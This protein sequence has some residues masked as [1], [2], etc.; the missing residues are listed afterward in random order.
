M[1]QTVSLAPVRGR[2]RIE[3]IDILRGVAIL[4]IFFVNLPAMMGPL[5]AL[6]GDIRSLG[7]SP[8]D[9]TTWLLMQTFWEGTQRGMLEFLFGAGLMV[10]AAKAMDGDGP[11]AVADLYIRRNLW[12][13]AFGLIN[14]FALLWIADILHVY[15]LSALALF[16]FRKLKVKWLI[17]IGLSLAT[18]QLAIGAAEYVSRTDLHQTYQ[19]ASAKRDKGQTLTSEEAA[20]VKEWN[21]RVAKVAAG[22]PEI[23]KLTKEEKAAR[24]GSMGDYAGFMISTY[25]WSLGKGVLL[26]N[27]LEAFSLML[28]G[29]AAWKLGFIQG[30]RSTRE[31]W[32]VLALAY[33]FGL[34]ARYVGALEIMA[35]APIPKTIWMTME[36]ARIAVTIGHIAAINLLVRVTA[37]RSLLAPF[38]AAGQ[39][40]FSLYLMQQIIGVWI[41]YS[42]VGLH[43]PSA[44]GWAYAA[45]LA[46]LVVVFQLVLANI[47]VRFFVSGPLEW[48]W[49]SLA[50]CRKQ[51]FRRRAAASAD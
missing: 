34:T 7:W 27:V 21:E 20:A 41:L 32:L 18:L 51:P 30:K 43:L 42:P 47:W 16:P 29:I 22:D 37:G 3:V 10:T 13:L 9:Q 28:L 6:L 31:Y 2:E 5:S 38:K 23:V 8:A 40:A 49:R 11:V 36:F 14:I 17:T 1:T 12:L 15:A 35:F 48:V 4:G 33:G 19:V 44:Q 50:Y 46:G 45:G 26:L 39:V 25:L 24:A